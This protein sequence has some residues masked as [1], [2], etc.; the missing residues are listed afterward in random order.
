MG[1]LTK[2]P[3]D[4]DPHRAV[5]ELCLLAGFA[6]HP[7]VTDSDGNVVRPDVPD[8]L[9]Q[10]ALR[11]LQDAHHEA[12]PPAVDAYAEALSVVDAFDAVEGF[13]AW[14]ANRSEVCAG[15]WP[16]ADGRRLPAK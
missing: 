3:V 6:Q 7:V 12:P 4:V 8:S 13:A 1:R 5:W 9:A 10:R 14:R 11:T 2:R 16:T 15:Y